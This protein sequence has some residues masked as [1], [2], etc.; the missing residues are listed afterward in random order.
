MASRWLLWSCMALLGAPSL[1]GA[2]VEVVRP[3]VGKTGIE[4]AG[5][6]ADGEAGRLFLHTLERNLSL[7]GLFRV[8]RGHAAGIVAQ[9]AY[10]QS[11]T[12][13]KA[14]V[15]V[16]NRSTRQRYF[17]KT[18]RGGLDETRRMAQN[19]ADDIVESVAGGAGIAATR[20]ALIGSVQGVK[21][22]YICDADGGGLV[23]VTRDNAVSLAPAWFPDARRVLYTSFHRGYPD[24]Y[25]IDLAQQQRT[26]LAAFPGL[27]MSGAVSPDGKRM[28]LILSKDGHP[29]LYVM[30]LRNRAVRR[31]TRTPQALAA[32]P[33]WSPDGS[34]IVFVSDRAG[35]RPHLYVTDPRGANIR[36]LTFQGRENVAPDWGPNG[37]IAYASRR[38]GR[39]RLFVIDPATGHKRQVT[40]DEADYTDPAWAPNGRHIACTRRSGYRSEVYIVDTNDGSSVRLFALEGDWYSPAWSVKPKGAK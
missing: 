20:I 24:I 29:D 32:S 5:I 14:R 28:A 18:Y 40:Q 9:G 37:L 10:R 30:E 15:S 27:N 8:E 3:G 7:S 36:R 26:A 12:G 4:I 38:G 33:S 22:L 2:D 39:Y 31:V 21:N 16:H 23:Q 34:E 35:G 13:A 25:A 11:G 19:L 1:H 17:E 6:E